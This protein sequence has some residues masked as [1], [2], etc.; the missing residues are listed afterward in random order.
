MSIK[1]Y[2]MLPYEELLRPGAAMLA[3]Y[4]KPT[5]FK[6]RVQHASCTS[7]PMYVHIIRTLT[8]H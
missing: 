4:K 8:K 6:A 1:C 2:A 7:Q 3:L 5:D